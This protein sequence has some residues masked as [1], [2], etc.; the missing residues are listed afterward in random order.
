MAEQK[1]SLEA[2]SEATEGLKVPT[3]DGPIAWIE[4]QIRGFLLRLQ[5]VPEDGTRAVELSRNVDAAE[6]ILSALQSHA[7]LTSER[8]ALKAQ[9]AEARKALE[10]ISE[11]PS[12]HHDCDD[13]TRG[14][15]DCKASMAT[16]A[17]AALSTLSNAAPVVGSH[18]HG[19]KS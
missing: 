18:N 2:M 13:Y 11:R 6:A 4:K 12:F 5:V 8:D 3:L 17:E 19:N 14:Y 15:G 9:L 1:P 16:I 7:S 10:K